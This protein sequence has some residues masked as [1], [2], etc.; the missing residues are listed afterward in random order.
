MLKKLN[1]GLQYFALAFTFPWIAPLV[2]I[3]ASM[4]I[5]AAAPGLKG[6]LIIAVLWG[7]VVVGFVLA[8]R[9]E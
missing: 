9:E 4:A 8:L 1:A 7:A 6:G 2:G 3:L 5:L